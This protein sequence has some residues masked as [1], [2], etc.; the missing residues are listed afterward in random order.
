MGPAKQRG[1]VF[2]LLIPVFVAALAWAGYLLFRQRP[3]AIPTPGRADSTSIPTVADA[4]QKPPPLREQYTQAGLTLELW[5]PRGQNPLYFKGET[6][7]VNAKASADCHI[8]VFDVTPDSSVVWLV[9]DGDGRNAVR[10][11]RVYSISDD[12]GRA[13]DFT[14]SP[15]Y[16]SE[17][18]KAF[19]AGCRL[20]AESLFGLPGTVEE[21]V[22]RVRNFATGLPGPVP[23]AEQ[24]LVLRSEAKR[25]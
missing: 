8:Y 18:I 17:V 7:R 20:P 25:E 10:G 4:A 21:K 9:S 3:P 1:R 12:F 23:Y 16:G 14:V 19:A 22:L 2:L 5:T 24:F 13:V 11:Q 15:P 6:V